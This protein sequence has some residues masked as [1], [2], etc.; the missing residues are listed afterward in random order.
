MTFQQLKDYF[1]ENFGEDLENLPRS[2]Q[3]RYMF[4]AD[5]VGAVKSRIAIIEGEILRY[6]VEYSSKSNVATDKEREL[7]YI[8]YQLQDPKNHNKPMMTAEEY[9]KSNERVIY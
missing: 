5:L 2:L 4:L 9:E 8:R 3:G 6:G 1:F 7:S